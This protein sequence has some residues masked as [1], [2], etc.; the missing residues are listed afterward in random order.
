SRTVIVALYFVLGIVNSLVV[1]PRMGVLL[2]SIGAAMYS[3]VVIM[4][5]RG[6]LPFAPDGPLWLQSQPP[7]AMEG[8]LQ[9]FL[10]TVLL[11]FGTA[12]VATLLQKINQRENQLLVANERLAELS[13]QDPLTKLWNRRHILSHIEQGLAWLN[14]GRP[15]AVVM[16]DLDQFKRVNDIHGHLEGDQV[17]QSVADA[18]RRST[19]EVDVVGRYGGDEFVIVLPDT[20]HE[21]GHIA[22]NRFVTAIREVG[23]KFDAANPVM[24]SAGLS[25]ARP[26]DTVEVVLKRADDFAYSAKGKGGN[27]LCG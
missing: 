1:T 20:N 19:R 11:M 16:I 24:A 13:R 18:L 6:A 12:I 2:S 10:V 22:G 3:T 9:A 8:F 4:E 26:G 5:V 23:M 17:L 7:D 15:M 27:R 14:R 21:E 25:I